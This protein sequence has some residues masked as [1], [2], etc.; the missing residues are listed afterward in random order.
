MSV[1]DHNNR[2][3]MVSMQDCQQ[4][5]V[6]LFMILTLCIHPVSNSIN[7]VALSSAACMGLLII[8]TAKN[9]RL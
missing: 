1:R 6:I 4:Y 9:S 2:V 8:C 5:G 7:S 3:D